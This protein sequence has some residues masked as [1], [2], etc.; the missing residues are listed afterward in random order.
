MILNPIHRIELPEISRIPALDG[1]QLERPNFSSRSM[2]RSL[3][4][5][6]QFWYHQNQGVPRNTRGYRM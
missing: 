3:R 4:D 6:K 1:N 2:K 5:R